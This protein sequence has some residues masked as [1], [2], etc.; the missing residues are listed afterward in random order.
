MIAAALTVLT[1]AGAY[2]LLLAAARRRHRLESRDPATVA[3][4]RFAPGRH[5][6]TYD[7]SPDLAPTWRRH[8]P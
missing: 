4:Q 8:A 2:A 1:G 7:P 3:L 6:G 5:V